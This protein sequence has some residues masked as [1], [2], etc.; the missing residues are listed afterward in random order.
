MI[1]KHYDHTHEE[2][3]ALANCTLVTRYTAK[4]LRTQRRAAAK[5]GDRDEVNRI[6]ACL[7]RLA[8]M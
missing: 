7:G 3:Y 5:R 1:I 2:G 8:G 4:R 6:E